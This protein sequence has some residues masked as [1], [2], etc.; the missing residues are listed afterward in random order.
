MKLKKDIEYSK[1]IE[2]Q[3]T[4]RE[5]T[6][7]L[8]RSYQ[9]L[10]ILEKL[11]MLET[12]ELKLEILEILEKPEDKSEKSE[13]HELAPQQKELQKEL[14][15]ELQTKIEKR[16]KEIEELTI[17]TQ[18][19]E[20]DI[21]NREKTIEK[22]TNALKKAEL[23]VQ[24]NLKKSYKQDLQHKLK[25]KNNQMYTLQNI[26]LSNNEKPIKEQK[27]A[28]NSEVCKCI[29]D[30]ITNIKKEEEKERKRKEEEEEKERK[31][32]EEEE[33]EEITKIINDIE[34]NPK[35]FSMFKILGKGIAS[36]ILIHFVSF[37]LIRNFDWQAIKSSPKNI[38]AIFQVIYSFF[39]DN[40]NTL[41]L[42]NLSLIKIYVLTCATVFVLWNFI[43]H[44]KNKDYLKKE[45]YT[46]ISTNELTE[47]RQE[48]NLISS[49]NLSIMLQCLNINNNF[50][51]N[52][53]RIAKKQRD[54]KKEPAKKIEFYKKFD[55]LLNQPEI[56]SKR[57][58]K[59][60]KQ[61]DSNSITATTINLDMPEKREIIKKIMD[62]K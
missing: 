5:K 23:Q 57:I 27:K 19:I 26:G 21:K 12:I 37:F 8:N 41:K 47:E 52:L 36:P 1:D 9:K 10:E 38:Q 6:T 18:N 55:Q 25:R 11:E 59:I 3:K 20:T 16:K 42:D 50:F 22:E 34:T 39:K 33:E 54:E 61:D 28:L 45:K 24:L 29:E 35:I 43:L 53:A 40:F 58:M 13:K 14:Q 56:F 60:L 48:I 62:C 46:Y 32:K 31:R 44:Q 49:D 7:S 30:N 51:F 17:E 4:L 2:H 15:T